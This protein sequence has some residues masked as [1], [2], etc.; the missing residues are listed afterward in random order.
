M[1]FSARAIDRLA[2][3]LAF[4]WAINAAQTDTFRVLVVEDFEG[5]AVEDAVITTALPPQRNPQ[6]T[7][8]TPCGHS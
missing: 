2:V 4:L 3:S 7:R 6:E 8:E 5:V 1:P